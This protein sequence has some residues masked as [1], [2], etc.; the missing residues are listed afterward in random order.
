MARPRTFDEAATL[1]EV[2][3][4]FWARGYTAT[5]LTDLEAAT[6]LRRTSLYAAFG[7]KRSLFA[8]VL[9]AYQTEAQAFLRE[10]AAEAATFRDAADRLFAYAIAQ[11]RA[12]RA[13]G[14]ACRGCLIANATAELTTVDEDA[15]A[16][17]ADNRE[18]FSA[19]LS[20]VATAD[21]SLTMPPRAACDYALAVYTG[22]HSLAKSGATD[23]EL[24]RVAEA[25]LAVLA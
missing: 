20:P 25:A 19:A 11:A 17:V 5:S 3:D 24:R 12:D 4:A 22:L 10:V 8:R 13:A 16:F 21:A 18:R 15:A 9:R 23:A 6:G 2:R 7:D 1:D 14:R